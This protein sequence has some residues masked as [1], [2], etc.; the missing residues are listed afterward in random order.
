M[1]GEISGPS[2]ER[3]SDNDFVVTSENMED[4]MSVKIN[5]VTGKRTA[6]CI[7]ESNVFTASFMLVQRNFRCNKNYFSD[8]SRFVTGSEDGHVT[9]WQDNLQKSVQLF[10]S[11]VL[12]KYAGDKIY[13][14]DKSGSK[15]AVLDTNLVVL[16]AINHRFGSQV[17]VLAATDSYVAVGELLSG[18]VTVFNNKGRLILVSAFHFVSIHLS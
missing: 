6:L 12:V 10:P 14:I 1:N 2:L 13:A 4:G 3:V 5:L 8:G 11:K 16:K 17:S 18:K 15:L 7:D 9:V